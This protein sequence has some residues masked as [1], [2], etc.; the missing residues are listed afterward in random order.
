MG[1]WIHIDS[2]PNKNGYFLREANSVYFYFTIIWLTAN[3]R[4]IIYGNISSEVI[5]NSPLH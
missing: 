4:Q 1:N 5:T 3:E 2:S